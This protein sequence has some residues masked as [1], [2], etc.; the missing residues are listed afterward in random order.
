MFIIHLV[1]FVLGK[2]I[3]MQE[4]SQKWTNKV[5]KR[6]VDMEGG[7]EPTWWGQLMPHGVT[8]QPTWPAISLIHVMCKVATP[9]ALSTFD[10]MS[11]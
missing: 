5:H 10:P 2:I 1:P 8:Q 11:I 3:C 4:F 7:R 9:G 6:Q